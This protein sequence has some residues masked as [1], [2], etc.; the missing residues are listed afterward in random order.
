[1]SAGT[2][3]DPTAQRLEPIATGA[4]PEIV[5][6]HLA[7]VLH[8]PRWRDCHVALISGGKSNL[9]YRVACDAG[10]VILRRPPLGQV[11]PTAHDMVREFRVQSALENT[12]VPVPRMLHLDHTERVLGAKFYVMD[13]VLGHNCL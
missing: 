11:L 8:D 3:S 5:G 6:P 12:H 1:M 10:E 7:E 4:E 9:T 13:R 2:F